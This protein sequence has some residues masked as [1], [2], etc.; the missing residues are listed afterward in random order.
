[1]CL[2]VYYVKNYILSKIEAFK[3]FYCEITTSAFAPLMN[4]LF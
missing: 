3:A 1:M 2:N 4:V